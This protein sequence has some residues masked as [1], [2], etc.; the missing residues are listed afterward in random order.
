MGSSLTRLKLGRLRT[1]KTDPSGIALAEESAF[2]ARTY[3]VRKK[4]L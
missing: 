4:P 3:L 1:K 2:M